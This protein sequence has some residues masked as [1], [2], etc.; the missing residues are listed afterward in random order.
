[1][2]G[3]NYRGS[4]PSLTRHPVLR[5]LV[6]ATLGTRITNTSGALVIP[7]G[8]LSGSD[9]AVAADGLVEPISCLAGFPHPSGGN[10][11]RVRQYADNKKTCAAR[12]HDGP[13]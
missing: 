13:L 6:R 8:K 4:S 11:H 1:M 3:Q 5:S 7:L 9:I 10:G 12:F 2:N